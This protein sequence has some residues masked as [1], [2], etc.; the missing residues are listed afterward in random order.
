[1]M[2]ARDPA[3]ARTTLPGCLLRA[4]VVCSREDGGEALRYLQA[5]WDEGRMV[6]PTPTE[7]VLARQA[8][9]RIGQM[10]PTLTAS[11]EGLPVDA[12][13]LE[14]MV[15]TLIAEGYHSGAASP[16][17]STRDSPFAGSDV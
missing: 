9:E 1:M 14:R 5:G 12:Q 7:R 3:V 11:L 17:V 13:Q 8:G 4:A 2:T 15:T 6:P 16:L 10:L